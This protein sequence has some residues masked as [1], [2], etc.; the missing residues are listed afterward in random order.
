M[1]RAIPAT[2]RIS[3]LEITSALARR[4]RAGDLSRA[5][6]D[7]IVEQIERDFEAFHVVEVVPR[8]VSAAKDLLLRHRLRAAD[9]IQ[10]G[11]ALILRDRLQRRIRFLAYDRRLLEAAEKEFGQGPVENSP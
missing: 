3:L 8:V 10:L 7:R 1:D 2:S 6:R 4:H 9:S 5:H 11:S